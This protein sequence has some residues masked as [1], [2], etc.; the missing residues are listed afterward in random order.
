V[1]S[2]GK[3]LQETIR[4]SLT[5]EDSADHIRIARGR[6]LDGDLAQLS[7]AAAGVLEEA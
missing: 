1:S 2:L 5:L 7:I 6:D 3:E 4:S